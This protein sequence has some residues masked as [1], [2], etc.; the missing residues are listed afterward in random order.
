[1]VCTETKFSPDVRLMQ[2][3]RAFDFNSLSDNNTKFSQNCLFTKPDVRLTQI[4]RASI[5]FPLSDSFHNFI[6]DLP[7]DIQTHVWSLC[8]RA[9]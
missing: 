8:E 7:F 4:E 3:R 2:D 6:P 9:S 5:I 1:M